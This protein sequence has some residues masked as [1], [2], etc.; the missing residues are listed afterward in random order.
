MISTCGSPFSAKP[1]HVSLD[2]V[3]YDTLHQ[4]AGN[5]YVSVAWVICHAISDFLVIHQGTTIGW[6][7]LDLDDKKAIL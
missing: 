2:A 1:R 7:H 5:G 3:D 4:L 6:L